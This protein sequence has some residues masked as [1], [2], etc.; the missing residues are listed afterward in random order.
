MHRY[1]QLT[2]QQIE[3]WTAVRARGATHF[4]LVRGVVFFGGFF[5][6]ASSC[7]AYLEARALRGTIR[8]A[9]PAAA[10][11]APSFLAQVLPFGI[12]FSLVA[13][14]LFGIIVWLVQN[15]LVRQST[16]SGETTPNS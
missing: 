6:V 4:I 5:A 7:A 1:L 11:P 10:D 3:R 12:G 8:Q 2:P 13:G 16:L 15:W 14:L 9:F